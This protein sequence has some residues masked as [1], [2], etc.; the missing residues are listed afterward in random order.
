MFPPYTQNY[1]G[2]ALTSMHLHT[3]QVP[4]ILVQSWAG[5]ADLILGTV[6][7]LASSSKFTEKKSYHLKV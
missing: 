5:W 4:S 6:T 3:T 2:V 1:I 7:A